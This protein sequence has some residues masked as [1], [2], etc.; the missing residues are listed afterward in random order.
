ME[1]VGAAFVPEARLASSAC[2]ES[3]QDSRSLGDRKL[4]RALA[5]RFDRSATA[6]PRDKNRIL[7]AR[8]RD[9]RSDS[10]ARSFFLARAEED[11]SA[12]RSDRQPRFVFSNGAAI[13]ETRM[14]IQVYDDS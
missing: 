2:R 7:A 13:N 1:R 10:G 11:T 9:T 12:S 14:S 5:S 4:C 8:P 3:D 6:K